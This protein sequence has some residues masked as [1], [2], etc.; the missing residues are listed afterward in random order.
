MV[1]SFID[2][3]DVDHVIYCKVVLLPFLLNFLI[4][5]GICLFVIIILNIFC[6]VILV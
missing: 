2:A 4:I 3:V 5:V 1:N 6:I